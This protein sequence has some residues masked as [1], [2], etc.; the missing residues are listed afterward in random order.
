MNNNVINDI[1]EKLEHCSKG[2]RKI[3]EYLLEN[4]ASAAYM[5]AA[6]LSETVGDDTSATITELIDKAVA[7]NYKSAAEFG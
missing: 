3:G 2:Q 7:E 6:K 4:Y 1:S 5:T